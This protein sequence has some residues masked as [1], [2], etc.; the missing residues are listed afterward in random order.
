MASELE[1]LRSIVDNLT[2]D[3]RELARLRSMVQAVA[4]SGHREGA[5]GIVLVSMSPE[6]WLRIQAEHRGQK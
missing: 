6:L 5:G 2:A 3:D 1:Y 4:N